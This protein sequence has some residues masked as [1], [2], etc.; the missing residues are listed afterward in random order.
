MKQTQ[1][2]N[3]PVPTIPTSPST[4][5]NVE[6]NARSSVS[7]GEVLESSSGP[8]P[9]A[10]VIGWP[11]DH[12][13]SPLIFRYWFERLSV[14]GTYERIPCEPSTFQEAIS[15]LI[16][17]GFAGLNVTLPHKH[18]ALEFADV[19]TEA[20]IA[21]GAANM[22]NLKLSRIEADNSDWVGFLAPL[23]QLRETFKLQGKIIPT[24]AM[25]LGAGGAAR[26]VLYGLL[27]D[28][29]KHIVIANRSLVRAEQVRQDFK[30]MLADRDVGITLCSL[31]EWSSELC[32]DQEGRWV[33][34]TTS[35][36]MNGQPPLPCLGM[37]CRPQDVAY[38]LVYKPSI[39]EFLRQ[40]EQAGAPTIG[41]LPMLIRQAI[42]GFHRWFDVSRDPP[43][44]DEL[45]RR[46]REAAT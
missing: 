6:L 14:A 15:Q 12:S 46:I 37:G 8:G 24:R 18:A 34:Q 22:L 9:S 16:A 13:L 2:P 31:D 4:E 33:V 36:G 27:Q 25:V 20:A 32:S 11:V 45:I 3:V 10:G 19:A 43:V 41:G 1:E 26:A 5:S 44:D 23:H 7:F 42:P 35:L 28:G 30:Q 39:T 17:S 40:A 29:I 38:D 21:I